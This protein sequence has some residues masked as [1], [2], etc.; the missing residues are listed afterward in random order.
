ML[1]PDLKLYPPAHAGV[2]IHRDGVSHT[3]AG[4]EDHSARP[5]ITR[6]III[7]ASDARKV[8]QHTTTIHRQR[9]IKRASRGADH[10]APARRRRP[11]PPHR[12]SSLGIRM[13]WLARLERGL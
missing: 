8:A 6:R 11:C 7:I 12:C 9:R 1:L 5:R 13:R 10:Y 4:R 3:L 2:P